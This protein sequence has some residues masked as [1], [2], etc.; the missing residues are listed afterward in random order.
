MRVLLVDDSALSRMMI[1]S[2]L[3]DKFPD[4]EIVEAGSGDEAL[5]LPASPPF[6][7]ITI[8]INMPGMDSFEAAKLLHEKYPASKM[9]VI[10]ANIQNSIRK[11]IQSLGIM[12]IAVI[13]KP[14]TEERME[15]I[16][17]A[18]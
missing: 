12:F 1:R 14:V 18:L 2:L 6:D 3:S 7:L 4:C 10:T 17:G 16:I 13:E 15:K 11:K 8:D 9:A 5:A